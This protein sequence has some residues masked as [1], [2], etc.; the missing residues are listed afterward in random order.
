[1]N[2]NID[3]KEKEYEIK[4][5]IIKSDININDKIKNEG[6]NNEK[7]ERKIFESSKY[8][9]KI[10]NKNNIFKK[11]DSNLSTLKSTPKKYKSE[12]KLVKVKGPILMALEKFS[13]KKNIIK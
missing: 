1:M 11:D 13:S 10:K 5:N 12:S 7:N 6:E 8:I 2:N 3:I 9:E 4:T